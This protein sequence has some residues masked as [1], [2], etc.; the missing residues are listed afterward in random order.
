[1]EWLISA[2]GRARDAN[3]DLAAKDDREPIAR[4]KGD[5]ALQTA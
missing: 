3:R 5:V 2:I 1:M 4:V